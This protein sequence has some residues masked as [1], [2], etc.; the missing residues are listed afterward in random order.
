MSISNVNVVTAALGE[1]LNV[2]LLPVRDTKIVGKRNN[3]SVALRRGLRKR[4]GKT[5]ERG[6]E[7]RGHESE[8]EKVPARKKAILRSTTFS[9]S[10]RAKLRTLRFSTV[11]RRGLSSVV[12]Q[13]SCLVPLYGSG[14]DRIVG[15]A[16][17]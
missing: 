4:H 14:R 8:D 3:P 10:S 9:R 7:E 17:L 16:V 15:G 1:M 6:R 2:P 13:T 12:H 11:K 5:K